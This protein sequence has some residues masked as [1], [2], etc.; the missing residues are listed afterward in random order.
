MHHQRK[1]LRPI[2][3]AALLGVIALILWWLIEGDASPLYDF[4][5]SHS[6]VI[7]TWYALN[8]MPIYIGHIVAILVSGNVHI[9]NYF[10]YGFVVF[11]Q[12]FIVG[13]IVSVTLQYAFRRITVAKSES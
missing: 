3:F 5:W 11:A 7:E 2:V 1:V 12:W 9:P 13:Y 4:L 8:R 6:V 10:A